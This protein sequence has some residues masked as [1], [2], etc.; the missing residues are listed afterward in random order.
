MEKEQTKKESIETKIIK[1]IEKTGYPTELQ[2]ASKMISNGW[3]V[4]HNPSYLDK[5]EDK[6]REFDIEAIKTN[7]FEF[8]LSR[9]EAAY[10]PE[11]ELAS[12]KIVKFGTSVRLLCEC[13]KSD[14]PWVFFVS[15]EALKY[16]NC[17]RCSF[18][19][20]H[21]LNYKRLQRNGHFVLLDKSFYET[22]HYYKNDFLA[23]TFFEP[24]KKL[25]KPNSVSP[26]IHAAVMSC[27]NATLYY[28]EIKYQ[29]YLFLNYP[30][31]IFQG[32]LF[33]SN[34]I[35]NKIE[36]ERTN[37]VQLAFNLI[38]SDKSQKSIGNSERFI[39]DIIKFEYLEEYLKIIEVELSTLSKIVED[40][41]NKNK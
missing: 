35:E 40:C 16:L 13:K 33:T 3:N 22:H 10:T 29:N 9:L 36:I 26:M 6:S 39:I 32:E 5:N 20:N 25:D 23:R 34:I 15:K 14:N 12:K 2:S 37:H 19:Y 31:I 21:S 18:E 7:E 4:F 28:E 17:T 1:E 30:V 8:R 41:F 24:F 11:Q 27:I 38:L